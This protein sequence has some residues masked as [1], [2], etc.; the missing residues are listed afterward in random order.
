MKYTLRV[1]K[2]GSCISFPI[3]EHIYLESHVVTEF[4]PHRNA[5]KEISGA[6]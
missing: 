5:T 2:D 6:N 1:A 3:V 4:D